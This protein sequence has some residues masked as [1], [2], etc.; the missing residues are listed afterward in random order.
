MSTGSWAGVAATV[1]S[2]WA[3]AGDDADGRLAWRD[4]NRRASLSHRMS[5][6]GLIA[7]CDGARGRRGL[8]C[9]ARQHDT[10]DTERAWGADVGGAGGVLVQD[11]RIVN[12]A[13]SLPGVAQEVR[14]MHS[15]PRRL[16]A[17]D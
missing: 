7:S 12:S 16:S 4:L 3:F 14:A 6:I 8:H 10:D 5:L 11:W 9:F 2:V 17:H 13:P 1:G 15:L